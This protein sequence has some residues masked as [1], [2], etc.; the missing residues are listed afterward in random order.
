M[1][2]T[3]DSKGQGTGFQEFTGARSV[4][5]IDRSLLPPEAGIDAVLTSL[6]PEFARLFYTA[7]SYSMY[8]FQISKIYLK[9]I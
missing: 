7:T 2:S 3:L 4:T 8:Q 6:L 9:I 5:A 1:C